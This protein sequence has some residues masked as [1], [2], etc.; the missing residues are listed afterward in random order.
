[1]ELLIFERYQYSYY[2]K[3]PKHKENYVSNGRIHEISSFG[4]SNK[5]SNYFYLPPKLK[6][7]AL[8]NETI[9]TE[10]GFYNVR[11]IE[12][13]GLSKEISYIGKYAFSG[14]INLKD[15]YYEG[16]KEEWEKVQIIEDENDVLLN[17]TMHFNFDI[18]SL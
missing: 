3:S 8:T 11:T 18:E 15:V 12:K 5:W 17:A 6:T 1:M 2:T 16:T 14:C 9:I 10:N 4:Y 13:L 7:I